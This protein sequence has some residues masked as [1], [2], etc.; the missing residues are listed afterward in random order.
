M[1][2]MKYGLRFLNCRDLVLEIS[3]LVLI[4]FFGCTAPGF[5]TGDNILNVLR[6]VSMQGI[7]AFAMT[8]VIISGEIDLSVGSAV[9]FSG[10]LTA[11]VVRGLGP[12]GLGMPYAA[13][14][15]VA[16]A[17]SLAT[18]FAIGTMTGVFRTR[19]NVPTF[20]TTLA[21]MTALTGASNL[22]TR[23]FPLTPYPDAFNFLGGGYIGVVPFPAIL[24]VLVFLVFHL[25]ANFTVFG[26]AVYA[27]GGNAEAARL[28]GIPVARVKC[29]VIGIASLCSF[30]AG[31]LVSSQIMSG[32][33][34]A[35]RGWE[36][37]VISA[38]IIGGVSM[39]G[40]SGSIAKTFIGIVFL[41]IIVNGMTLLNVNEYWQYVVKGGL[42]LGAVLLNQIQ[43]GRERR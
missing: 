35:A 14:I 10:C 25:V 43:L 20:I 42:I 34:T 29:M 33:P 1:I 28:S 2:S 38:V 21:L 37:D 11:F 22:L 24:F 23:G 5:L 4:L 3:L 16:I 30:L 15:P 26:R 19:W 27:I 39:Q 41:G 32:T 12:A 17:C 36:L 7:I 6:N 8:L 40:G 31:I 18:G 9:A 13:A